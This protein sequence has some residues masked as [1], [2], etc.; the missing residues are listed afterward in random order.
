ME[1]P[2]PPAAPQSWWRRLLTVLRSWFAGPEPGTTVAPPEPLR[3][4]ETPRREEVDV[5]DP[6]EARRA[7]READRQLADEFRRR[8]AEPVRIT[9]LRLRSARFFGDTDWELRPRVNVLLGANGYGKSLILRTLA[10]MLQRDDDVTDIVM[11][12]AG[13]AARLRLDLV[14]GASA[15]RIERDAY[16]FLEE[17]PRVPLLAI[18]DA[19]FVDRSARGSPDPT[20]Q[21]LAYEGA[22]QFLDQTPYQSTIDSLLTALGIEYLLNH[23]SFDIPSFRLLDRVLK[24]LTGGRFTFDHVRRQGKIGSEIYVRTEG[25][26]EPMPIKQASQGTLSI[27]AMFGIIQSFLHD[28]AEK[29]GIAED[30]QAIVL[31]DEVDA[32]LHPSWQQRIRGLL[33]DCF[34]T[35]QFILSAHSPLVVA[36]CGPGEVAVLRERAGG[37]S[38][39]ID[40]IEGDFVGASS[41]DLLRDL[42]GIEDRDPEFRRFANLADRGGDG[43]VLKTTHARIDALFA[44]QREAGLDSEETWELTEQVAKADA[45]GRVAK[46][47]DDERTELSHTVDLEVQIAQLQRRVAELE[48]EENTPEVA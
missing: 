22:R 27:V 38:F 7:S 35:V 33:V 3:E 45:I 34:P 40:E 12:R 44:K 32:H 28:V 36:G 1:Q 41:P 23:E 4:E 18:P 29:G 42:F 46:T 10:G 13:D 14:R 8:I 39:Y 26:G 2:A 31:I 16:S 11:A 47:L 24:D 20:T 9:S 25:L 17:T 37:G 21:E 43:E 5:S 48:A 6:Y 15:E 30:P 19:R